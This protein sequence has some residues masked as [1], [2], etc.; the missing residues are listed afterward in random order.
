MRLNSFPQH[1][2]LLFRSPNAC[3]WALTV[4]LSAHA[5]PAV[6]QSA[7]GPVGVLHAPPTGQ[8]WVIAGA[9]LLRLSTDG[10]TWIDITPELLPTEQISAAS[11]VSN[12]TGWLLARDLS[13]SRLTVFHTEDAATTWSHTTAVDSGDIVSESFSGHAE[14]SFIDARH[15]WLLLQRTS[16]A[17]SSLADLLTTSDGG[18]TW[19]RLRPPPVAGSLSFLSASRGWLSGGPRGSALYATADGGNSWLPVTLPSTTLVTP[20]AVRIQ[21]PSLAD[22][23]L[24]AS[25]AGTDATHGLTTILFRR[26]DLGVSWTPYKLFQGLRQTANLAMHPFNGSLVIALAD[27]KQLM[28][29]STDGSS[30]SSTLPLPDTGVFAIDDVIFQDTTHGWLHV[31]GT[32]CF[33][34]KTS[35]TGWTGLFATVDGG[36]TFSSAL[37]YADSSTM[38]TGTTPRLNS[39]SSTPTPDAYY[40]YNVNAHGFDTCDTM[41]QQGTNWLWDNTDDTVLGFYLGGETADAVGC[42]KPDYT[43]LYLIACRPWNYLPLWDGLQ[44]PCAAGMSQQINPA[45]AVSDGASAAAAAIN[46]LVSL[47]LYQSIAYLDIERY[48]RNDPSCSQAVKDYASAFI[49]TMHDSGYQAG[50]YVNGANA[51]DDFTPGEIDN[52][53]DDIWVPQYPGPGDAVQPLYVLD[54]TGF[55]YWNNHQRVHQIN[56][57]VATGISGPRLVDSDFVDGMTATGFYTCAPSCNDPCNP[58]C[59]NY[60]ACNDACPDYDPYQ[61]GFSQCEDGTVCQGYNCCPYVG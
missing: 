36:Q 29:W 30:Y 55:I 51:W 22:P 6:S 50:L 5:A 53:P 47:S 48:P 23:T 21:L 26:P 27:H 44:A 19:T 15:G 32:Q 60:D 20:D 42:F 12:S 41:Q 3:I 33:G 49:A 54:D 13:T 25:I 57:N 34:F 40:G 56:Q 17:A 1:S 16:G 24:T 58:S 28:V 18:Q 35:C 8:P 11:F 43:Q 59:D 2:R 46:K 38:S 39:A 9:R 61:C 52:L 10:G 4:A 37:T 7:P 14:F 31:A 45:T